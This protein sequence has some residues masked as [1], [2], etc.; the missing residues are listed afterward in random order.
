MATATNKPVT[1]TISTRQ[2]T[3]YFH[4][5]NL[6]GLSFTLCDRTDLNSLNTNYFVSFGVPYETSAFPQ[7]SALSLSRPELQ[8]LN[9]DKILIAPIPREEYNEI[10]DGRSITITVP[11]F[12]GA[13][14]MSAKTVVSSTYSTFQKKENNVLLGNNIAFL[15]CDAINLPYTGRTGNGALSHSSNTTWDTSSYI[16]RPAAVSYTDLAPLDINTDSRPWSG[17]NL[18]V[19]VTQNYPTNTNQGYNYDIPVGFAVLD[20]GFIVITHPDIVDNVPWNLGYNLYSNTLNT[21][22]GTTNIYFNSATVSQLEYWELN[23]NFKTSVVCLALPG[24]FFFTNNPTWDLAKNVT[25][26]NNNTNNFDPLYITEIGLYNRS[27]E[28]IAVAKLS[29]P[30]KKEYTNLITFN[31]DI[32][33]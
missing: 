24:E 33:I 18:A 3:S 14:D 23:I 12:S 8:Q 13:T 30:V 19:T 5:L 32:N 1:S 9:V 15:F 21:T 10:L 28:M 6:S 25:E 17:V 29:E 22:S 31:L 4:T 11:Q 27:N 2:E 7:N 26:L 20:K 16:N